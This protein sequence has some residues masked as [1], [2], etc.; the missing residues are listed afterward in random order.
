MGKFDCTY[1]QGAKKEGA[2]PCR[3][4]PHLA[5][6]SIMSYLLVQTERAVGRCY[7]RNGMFIDEDVPLHLHEHREI[8]KRLDETFHLVTGHEFHDDPDAL[9]ARLVQILVLDVERRLGHTPL[10]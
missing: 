7:G 4:A 9:F 1:L 5:A 3:E 10:L 6:E 2:F 8:V